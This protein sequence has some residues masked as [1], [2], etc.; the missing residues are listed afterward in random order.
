MKK[1]IIIAIFVSF[2]FALAPA[3]PGSYLD[4][5]Y[6]AYKNKNYK[7]AFLLYKKAKDVAN[8]NGVFKTDNFRAFYNIALFYDKGIGTKKNKI[9]AALNYYRAY[10]TYLKKSYHLKEFCKDKYLKQFKWTLKRLYYFE[11]DKRYF[12]KLKDLNSNCKQLKKILK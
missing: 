6:K 2:N 1:F 11:Q 3:I 12:Y 9:K 7:K 10:L 5:A 8:I 4:N